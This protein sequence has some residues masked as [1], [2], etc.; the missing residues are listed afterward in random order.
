MKKGINQ[1]CVLFVFTGVEGLKNENT[2][3]TAPFAVLLTNCAVPFAVFFTT[4]L[5]TVPTQQ[6]I[7]GNAALIV[8]I[9]AKGSDNNTPLLWATSKNNTEISQLLIERGAD[10]D[11]KNNN[12]DTPLLIA[13]RKNNTEIIELIES[14]RA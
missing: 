8:P 14:I 13:T 9:D 1:F 7:I 5:A 3:E 12:N 6:V 2:D 4:L 11:A 10:I